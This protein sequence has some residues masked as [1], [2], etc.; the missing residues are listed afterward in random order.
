MTDAEWAAW[1]EEIIRDHEAGRLDA[2]VTE[3]LADLQ[4]GRVM[5][6][7]T[8]LASFNDTPTEVDDD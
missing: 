7:A 1:D 6:I 3:A 4:E 2:L 5:D 8:F